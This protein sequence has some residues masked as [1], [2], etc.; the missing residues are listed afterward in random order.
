[1]II[2]KYCE[3]KADMF[4]ATKTNICFFCFELETIIKE[5]LELAEKILINVK[6]S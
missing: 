6:K 5:N 4:V 3:K 1:M 2:C